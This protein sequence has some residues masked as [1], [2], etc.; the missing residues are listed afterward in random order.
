M[1]SSHANVSMYAVTFVLVN[2]RFGLGSTEG[3]RI[4]ANVTDWNYN[5]DIAAHCDAEQCLRMHRFLRPSADGRLRGETG[6]PLSDKR[7]DARYG[8]KS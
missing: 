7:R 5:V 1:T 4:C 6:P 3:A 8:R 2:L